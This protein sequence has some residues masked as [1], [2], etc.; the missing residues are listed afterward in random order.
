M[1]SGSVPS[2]KTLLVATTAT[3]Q[4]TGKVLMPTSDLPKN[5]KTSLLLPKPKASGLW[6]TLS[7]T[8]L[9]Q[10]EA[11]SDRSTPTTNPATTTPPAR[12]QTGII[13]AKLRT[14]VLLTFPTLTKTTH[15]FVRPL[16][17]GL[18]ISLAP[19]ASMESALILSPRSPKTSGLNLAH[20][21]ESSKWV[22]SSTV[23]PPT[24]APTKTT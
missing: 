20:L 18:K 6:L 1:L 2:S 15:G 14:V 3:G 21:L 8:T 10:L 16:R 13:K 22:K 17:T 24:S 23:L 7:L 5:L 19:T 12:F 11:T 4:K 9:L